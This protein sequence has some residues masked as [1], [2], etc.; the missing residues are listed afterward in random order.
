MEKS[1][2]PN[3]DF[4]FVYTTEDF[5]VPSFVVGK[6]D[7]TSTVMLSFLPKFCNMDVTD[8]YKAYI[9]NTTYDVDMDKAK[10]DYVFFLDRSGSMGGTRIQQAKKALIL[11]LKSLPEDSYFNII[12]FG[13]SS[14]RIFQKSE[15]LD[16]SK[17]EVA[18][19]QV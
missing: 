11:F 3:K 7:T 15:K 10:G 2:V 16:F 12:S 8:A 4:E 19:K 13:S 17:I 1:Q 9:E 14:Q 18:I 5:Q 6:T